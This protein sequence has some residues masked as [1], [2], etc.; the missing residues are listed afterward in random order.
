MANLDSIEMADH[1]QSETDEIG[2]HLQEEYGNKDPGTH[3]LYFY[4]T[5]GQE[6]LH[7]KQQ[8]VIDHLH[9]ILGKD[10]WT[11]PQQGWPGLYHFK[12]DGPSENE[13][14]REQY[15]DRELRQELIKRLKEVLKP[16]S[17]HIKFSRACLYTDSSRDEPSPD[18][19]TTDEIGAIFEN[20]YNENAH[21]DYFYLFVQ[22]KINEECF[23][24]K[25]ID[26]EHI[27]VHDMALK[28]LKALPGPGEWR[29][30]QPQHTWLGMFF[31]FYPK[32]MRVLTERERE[33]RLNGEVRKPLI[34]KL[35][36]KLK[37]IKGD[38]KVQVILTRA[39]KFLLNDSPMDTT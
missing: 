5:L 23:V 32:G 6:I 9:S 1:H 39:C 34:K 22:A 12:Y 15:L 37:H 31:G 3:I 27:N 13:R 36:A 10:N 21:I 11:K 18:I 7:T 26:G 2:R 28:E 30:L 20:T 14:E 16:S 4:L 17:I 24:K 35:M 38:I 29:T 25:D 8:I 19:I 33:K